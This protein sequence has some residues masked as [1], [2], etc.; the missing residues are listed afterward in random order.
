MF[1]GCNVL[2]GSE[3]GVNSELVGVLHEHGCEGN[4]AEMFC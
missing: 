3:G 4:G 1:P 2:A